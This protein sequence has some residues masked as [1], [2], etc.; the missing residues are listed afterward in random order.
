MKLIEK[1]SEKVQEIIMLESEQIT[2]SQ[3]EK[4]SVESYFQDMVL[5]FLQAGYLTIAGFNEKSQIY[6]LAYPNAEIRLSMTEQILEFVANINSVKLAGFVVRFKDALQD[7]NI[8]AFC[9]AMKDFFVLLPHTVIIN[10][11]KF[12]QGVFFTVTKLLGAQI[13]VE[14]ATSLGYIDAVIYGSKNV[15]IIEF[16]R[17]KTPD[18]ALK[19]ILDKKY[20]AKFKIEGTKPIVLVGM[21]FD[22]DEKA[23]K[24]KDVHVDWKIKKI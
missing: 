19:Q 13:N 21:N 17:N 8:E 10:R 20:F 4:L 24:K 11:E 23:K 14:D 1:N 18:A 22:Y 15:Y 6:Q 3:M 16:K 9:S 7:D 12:Y 2:I 5:L